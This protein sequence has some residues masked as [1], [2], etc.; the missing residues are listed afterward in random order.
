[1]SCLKAEKEESGHRDAAKKTPT[2]KACKLSKQ[3]HT[4]WGTLLYFPGIS[5]RGNDGFSQRSTPRYQF[6]PC[7]DSDTALQPAPEPCQAP[8]RNPWLHPA[9]NRLDSASGPA[10]FLPEREQN[11]LPSRRNSEVTVPRFCWFKR[12]SDAQIYE[13]H[14]HCSIRSTCPFKISS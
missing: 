5:G 13:K 10:T 14:G 3:N 11:S 6:Q 2:L 12:D 7:S 8:G 4:Q 9:P 1:M